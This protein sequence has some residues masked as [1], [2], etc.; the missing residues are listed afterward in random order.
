M[1]S[2][3]SQL[4]EVRR[5]EAEAKA[6]LATAT[7]RLEKAQQDVWDVLA[8]KAAFESRLGE[9]NEVLE[10][11]SREASVDKDRLARARR[12]L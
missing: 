7:A 2:L 12:D 1:T 10:R 3:Q 4:E 9:T 8:E 6:E 5:Q 11:L